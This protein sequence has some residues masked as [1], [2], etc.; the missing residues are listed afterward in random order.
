[1]LLATDLVDEMRIAYLPFI[2]GKSISL[3][4]EQPKESKWRIT[5]SR[6]Y[7]SAVLMI[8]YQKIK[9]P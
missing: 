3:F 4:L 5:E 7:E 9:P 1:M 8:N 2:L 6:I